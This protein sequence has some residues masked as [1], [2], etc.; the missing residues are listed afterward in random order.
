[1]PGRVIADLERVVEAAVGFDI[2]PELPVLLGQKRM[3]PG[4]RRDK[5]GAPRALCHDPRRGGADLHTAMRV[6]ARRIKGCRTGI[7]D[8]VA[9]RQGQPQSA[10]GVDPA[11]VAIHR[12]LHQ[13][14]VEAAPLVIEQDDR[15]LEGVPHWVV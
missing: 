1:M 6:G 8:L 4:G 12:E 3:R 2:G 14:I 10:R 15:V 11:A 5:R 13:R 9:H 7:A